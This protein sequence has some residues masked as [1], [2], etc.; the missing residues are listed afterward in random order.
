MPK[1][2]FR[3][4]IL[5]KKNISNKYS[6]H[7]SLTKELPPILKNKDKTTATTNNSFTQ[8]IALSNLHAT[9]SEPKKIQIVHLS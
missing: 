4:N 2:I 5:P 9:P 8:P 1:I 7:I 6:T 3:T